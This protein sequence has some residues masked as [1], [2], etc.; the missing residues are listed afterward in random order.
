[1]N[2]DKTKTQIN[3]LL[4]CVQDLKVQMRCGLMGHKI[5]LSNVEVNNNEQITKYG[6][7]CIFC[8]VEYWRS[9]DNLNPKEREIVYA[10]R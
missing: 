5:S 2:K 10:I 6:F 3:D 8:D 1:M 4:L 9:A 7:K